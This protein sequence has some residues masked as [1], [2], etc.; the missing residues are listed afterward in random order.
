[1]IGITPGVMNEIIGLADNISEPGNDVE[2]MCIANWSDECACQVSKAVV[3]VLSDE[4][5][6]FAVCKPVLLNLQQHAAGH[7]G[8][9]MEFAYARS[10]LGVAGLIALLEKTNSFQLVDPHFIAS[11][12]QLELAAYCAENNPRIAKSMKNEF[13]LW[14]AGE[15]ETSKAIAKAGIKSSVFVLVVFKGG[16]ASALKKLKAK[17]LPKKEIERIKSAALEKVGASEKE[18]L[19]KIAVSRL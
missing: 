9:F 19:E 13:L 14:L 2:L 7:L 6:Q 8:V 16:V 12:R 15:H 3:H 1:M 11:E 18:L 17:K 4:P 5:K 10:E